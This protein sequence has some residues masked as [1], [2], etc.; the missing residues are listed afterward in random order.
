MA[1]GAREYAVALA[2]EAQFHIKSTFNTLWRNGHGGAKHTLGKRLSPFSRL[3]VI[4]HL[5][6]DIIVGLGMF[7]RLGLR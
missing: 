3:A 7:T 5:Y 2:R 4:A 6:N 1:R